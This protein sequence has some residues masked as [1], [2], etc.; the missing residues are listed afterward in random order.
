MTKIDN[1]VLY[2]LNLNDP[3]SVSFFASDDIE[4][5]RQVFD[6]DRD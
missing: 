4:A 6:M 3:E 1:E 2:T 5:L